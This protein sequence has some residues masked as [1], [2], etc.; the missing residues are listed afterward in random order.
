MGFLQ[1]YSREI[2]CLIGLLVV[3]YEYIV[4]VLQLYLELQLGKTVLIFNRK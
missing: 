4:W 2:I 3:H 1:Y